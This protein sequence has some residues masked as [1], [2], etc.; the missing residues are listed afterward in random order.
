M[1]LKIL[2][3]IIVLL[4]LL[5]VSLVG[6]H[7]LS[8]TFSAHANAN[9]RLK[10]FAGFTNQIVAEGRSDSQGKFNLNYAT[11]Y[12][13]IGLLEIQDAGSLLLVLGEPQIQLVGSSINAI[14]QLR[15][16]NSGENQYLVDYFKAQEAA[17]QT[18][19]VWNWLQPKYPEGDT[20]NTIDR[21][22]QNLLSQ[23]ER[24]LAQLPKSSYV[25]FY[26]PFRQFIIDRQN[27]I[28][29]GMRDVSDFVRYFENLDWHNK[30]LW[31]SGLLGDFLNGHFAMLQAFSPN[32]EQVMTAGIDQLLEEY[33]GMDHQLGAVATHLFDL[34]QQLNAPKMAEYLSF[35]ML[36]QNSCSLDMSQESRFEQYRAM[37]AGNI[38]EDLTLDLG[39]H[40]LRKN[41]PANI[42]NLSDIE[43]A[44]TLVVFWASWC[45]HCMEEMPKLVALQNELKVKGVQVLAV[46]LDTESAAFESATATHPWMGYCDLMRFDSP[47][48][49][50][51]FVFA[52]PSFYL[53]D[54]DRRIVK[55]MSSVAQLI[56]AI[57]SL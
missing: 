38:A 47:L 56:E 26:L 34:M 14:D 21:E 53:L 10:T 48:A 22:I 5:P 49:R 16:I 52:T 2:K 29:Q 4:L 17:A 35:Q 39:G 45:G 19:Q 50:D 31:H 41:L 55:N 15:W 46:S 32:P 25:Q 43:S 3:S 27:Q 54:A 7:R 28:S 51:Y 36:E 6:Q 37:K 9:V 42:Q 23:D 1:T 18:L 11:D 13:G 30:D 20:R 57:K 33:A 40:V 44:Y 8:G 12:R 24:H